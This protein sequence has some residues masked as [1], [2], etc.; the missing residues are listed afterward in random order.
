M[1]GIVGTNHNYNIDFNM[2]TSLLKNRGPDNTSIKQIKNNFFGHTR[3]SIIDL[4]SEANQP[5]VFDDILI[6]FNG[7][8]YNYDELKVSEELVCKTS[9]DTE[10]LIR[11]YQK[12][13]VEFLNLLNGAFSFCIYDIVREIL[14]C[15]R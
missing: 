2:V 15:T 9:S 7:E 4:D 6:V 11:L 14:L 1:C 13:G 5:M 12:Y 8:I 10:V 3:L